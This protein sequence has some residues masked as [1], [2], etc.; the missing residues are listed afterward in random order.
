MGFIAK[1][2]PGVID[3][4]RSSFVKNAYARV[5]I[6]KKVQP[7]TTVLY[8]TCYIHMLA[9]SDSNVKKKLAAWQPFQE[10]W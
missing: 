2:H 6:R 5:P 1:T 3:C 4:S 10:R 8:T 7:C 9:V